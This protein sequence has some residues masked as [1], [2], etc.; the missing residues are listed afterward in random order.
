MT[1]F[2]TPIMVSPGPVHVDPHRW[3]G[4]PLLHHRSDAFR[5]IVKGTERLIASL[6]GTGSPVYIVTASGTG[7]MEM[8]VANC[9]RPGSRVLVVT[10]GKFGERWG[11][12][13]RAYGCTPELLSFAKGEAVDTEAVARRVEAVRP[14]L[15]MLTQVESSTGLLCPIAELIG[16]L[17]TPRPV[18]VVDAI[19]SLGAEELAMDDWGIDVVVAASQK[20][21]AAPPGIGFV[22]MS[23]RAREITRGSARDGPWPGYYF[24]IDRYERGRE[25]G[26]SPFTPAIQTLQL[27]HDSLSHLERLGW[28]EVR[29]IHR[30]AARAFLTAAGHLSL[31]SFPETPSAAVQALLLPDGCHG[32]RVVR[33]LFEK[34]R[35]IIAGGQGE[36]KG[37]I[38]RTGFLGVHGGAA[39][40]HVVG[41]LGAVLEGEGFHVDIDAAQATLHDIS[42]RAALFCAT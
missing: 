22:S 27:V 20:A 23:E 41:A 10:G 3:H 15:L 16:S 11:E 17:P 30:Q 35:V 40:G 32:E 33:Q 14:D 21:F 31:R 26:D 36:L 7:A 2:D 29:R 18:T 4:I 28:R 25:V 13:C 12:I 34:Q 8:A 5:E 38:V 39:I 9:V 6:I 24:D 37:R 1:E 42:D 19:A